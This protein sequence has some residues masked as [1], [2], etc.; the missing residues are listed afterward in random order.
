MVRLLA[1]KA[2][3]FI[4]A[5]SQRGII[6][7]VFFF[8][9]LRLHRVFVWSQLKLPFLFISR[10]SPGHRTLCQNNLQSF[11][12]FSGGSRLLN[13]P[14]NPSPGHR[15]NSTCGRGETIFNVFIILH[16]ETL[17]KIAVMS[18]HMVREG[19]V[20]GL[21]KTQRSTVIISSLSS[22]CVFP[23]QTGDSAAR[24]PAAL[25]PACFWVYE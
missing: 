18:A 25:G 24:R 23:K 12:F 5:H 8:Y 13:V 16:Q 7:A 11:L 14:W 3:H 19:R 22:Q 2:E 10:V 20:S 4:P 1:S 9:M 21:R 15:L 17:Y 6:H